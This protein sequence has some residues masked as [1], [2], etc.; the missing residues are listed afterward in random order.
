MEIMLSVHLPMLCAVLRFA[1]HLQNSF[2]ILIR[3]RERTLKTYLKCCW[4]SG[5][6]VHSMVF[7]FSYLKIHMPGP[8]KRFVLF[9]QWHLACWQCR[10]AAAGGSF[11]LTLALL[12]T[13]AA[14]MKRCLGLW[15]KWD[16]FQ[17]V[18]YYLTV[19]KCRLFLR[20]LFPFTYIDV[21]CRLFCVES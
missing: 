19:N 20:C 18:G 13:W 8:S 16:R 12:Q 17:S 10:P 11:P 21:H 2:K 1:V 7:V 15:G 14:K 4:W 6:F 5:W 9:W 3:K